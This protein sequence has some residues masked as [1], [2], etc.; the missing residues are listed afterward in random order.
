[1]IEPTDAVPAAAALAA[2]LDVEIWGPPGSGSTVLLAS[3]FETFDHLRELD[4]ATLS[5]TLEQAYRQLADDPAKAPSGP[6]GEER[7]TVTL[8]PIDGGRA[9]RQRVRIGVGDA[10]RIGAAIEAAGRAGTVVVA[11]FNPCLLDVE[12]AWKGLRHLV[13]VLQGSTVGLSFT[14]AVTEAAAAVLHVDADAVLARPRLRA[15]LPQ[16]ERTTLTYDAAQPDADRRFDWGQIDPAFRQQVC[17]ELRR[18]IHEQ[19]RL[20]APV[21]N[22]IRRGLRSVERAVVVLTHVDL[23]EAFAPTVTFADVERL[24]DDLFG[25]RPVRLANQR[26]LARPFHIEVVSPPADGQPAITRRLRTDGA[27][28]VARSLA[29]I[30]DHGGA[31]VDPVSVPGAPT[32]AD[33]VQAND[34]RANAETQALREQVKELRAVIDALKADAGRSAAAVQTLEARLA[35]QRAPAAD[36]SRAELDA[37]RLRFEELQGR[38]RAEIAR[39]DESIQSLS[40]QVRARDA[41]VAE[42]RTL[43]RAAEKG[44]VADDEARERETY[45]G[46]RTGPVQLWAATVVR[47][48][49]AVPAVAVAATPVVRW[50]TGEAAGHAFVVASGVGLVAVVVATLAGVGLRWREAGPRWVWFRSRNDKAGL[51]D[52]LT[53]G[54]GRVQCPPSEF[55]LEVSPVMELLGVGTVRRGGL[56]YATTEPDAWRAHLAKTQVRRRWVVDS[57][58][59]AIVV[60]WAVA[61]VLAL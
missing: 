55:T 52:V 1:M 5:P 35:A 56:A 8:A 31:S 41:Q 28:G 10:P 11:C 57:A 53:S 59:I 36:G 49:P 13:A 51:F 7:L 32:V 4:S 2:D 60:A 40:E 17:D 12:V 9:V 48:I 26:V 21:V 20:N 30:L 38:T 44:G 54:G 27:A 39:R 25:E 34:G 33:R 14:R 19:V 58:T 18:L 61:V 29:S 24:F 15:L 3:L 45:E 16:L 50:A 22:A 23:I 47:A 46:G 6:T 43:R 42:E 37:A